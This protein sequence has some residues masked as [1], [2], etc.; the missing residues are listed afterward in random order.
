[1]QPSEKLEVIGEDSR[2]VMP[3]G[4]SRRLERFR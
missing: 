2:F 4:G 1:M 3:L